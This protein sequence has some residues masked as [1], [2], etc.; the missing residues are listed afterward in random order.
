MRT[1]CRGNMCCNIA[2]SSTFSHVVSFCLWLCVSHSD[3]LGCT[4]RVSHMAVAPN[5]VLITSLRRLNRVTIEYDTLCTKKICTR[6]LEPVV[7]LYSCC[8]VVLLLAAHRIDPR[9]VKRKPVFGQRFRASRLNA[10][11]VSL[12]RP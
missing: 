12:W 5:A 4:I 10:R 2:M 7:C 6:I 8:G 3:S 1:N 11:V 9:L